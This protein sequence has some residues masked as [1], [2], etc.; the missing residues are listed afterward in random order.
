MTD[1]TAALLTERNKTHG[2]FS[3]NALISQQIKR[4]IH[5]SPGWTGL[6]DEHKE[7]LDMISMKL[8]RILS[9]HAEYEDHWDDIAGYAMLA[10]KAKKPPIKMPG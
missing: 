8:S 3:N 5:C 10:K 1:G 4:M 6:C 2:A 7:A 9:G